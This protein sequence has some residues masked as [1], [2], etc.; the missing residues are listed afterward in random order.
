MDELKKIYEFTF[1]PYPDTYDP[2]SKT[3]TNARYDEVIY[4]FRSD[5]T[6]QPPFSEYSCVSNFKK[7][8]FVKYHPYQYE[9]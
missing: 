9:N 2:S 7:G 5:N 1:G 4:W 6:L 3:Y 8:K